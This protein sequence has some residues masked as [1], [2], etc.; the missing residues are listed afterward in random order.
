MS[1]PEFGSFVLY[2]PVKNGNILFHTP[3][4]DIF[5]ILSV[6]KLGTASGLDTGG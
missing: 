5:K 1:F 6:A 4:W 2:H 3:G